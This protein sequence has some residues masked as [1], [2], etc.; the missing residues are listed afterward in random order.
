M[1]DIN[2]INHEQTR[3]TYGGGMGEVGIEKVE[4]TTPKNTQ[5]F[6][7]DLINIVGLLGLLMV[8]KSNFKGIDVYIHISI[9]SILIFYFIGRYFK[10]QMVIACFH[11]IWAVLMIVTPILSGNPILLTIHFIVS[12][13]SIF[14]RKYFGGCMI[15]ALEKKNNIITNNSMADFFNWDIIFPLLAL[16]S[17][18]KLMVFGINRYNQLANDS[19]GD[20]PDGERLDDIEGRYN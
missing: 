16:A 17:G 6:A 4:E 19:Y 20:E 11:F 5:I 8:D 14:T 1:S 18:V 7:V 10:S 2:K 3:E 15:R 9:V 13:L 12:L